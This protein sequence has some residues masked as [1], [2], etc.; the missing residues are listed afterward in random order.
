MI[1]IKKKKTNLCD[2][3]KNNPNDKCTKQGNVAI[4]LQKVTLLISMVKIFRKEN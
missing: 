3:N 4:K 1:T 2:F